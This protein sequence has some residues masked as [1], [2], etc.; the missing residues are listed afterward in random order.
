MVGFT[1][2]RWWARHHHYWHG[3]WRNYLAKSAAQD[4]YNDAWHIQQYKKHDLLASLDERKRHT[5]YWGNHFNNEAHSGRRRN[6]WWK[7]SYAA[8]VHWDCSGYYAEAVAK[9]VP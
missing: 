1:H 5:D 8:Q 3:G 9:I 4:N 6:Q 7:N 2:T